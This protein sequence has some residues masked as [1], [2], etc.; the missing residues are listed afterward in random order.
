[1]NMGSL[2]RSLFRDAERMAKSDPERYGPI[3]EVIQALRQAVAA[4]TELNSYLEAKRTQDNKRA[5]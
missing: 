3:L 1:M 4:Q 5:H 2:T